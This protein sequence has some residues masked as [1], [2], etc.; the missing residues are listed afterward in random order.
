M[1][2]CVKARDEMANSVN[3][4][5]TAHEKWADLGFVRLFVFPFNNFC[6]YVG[7]FLP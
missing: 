2:M 7:R 6:S 4:D 5:Q 3:L 1:M